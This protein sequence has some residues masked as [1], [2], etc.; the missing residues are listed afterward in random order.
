M[1]NKISYEEQAVICRAH[2]AIVKLFNKTNESVGSG[3]LIKLG[4]KYFIA[5]AAHVIP[6]KHSIEI[7]PVPGKSPIHRFQ[8]RGACEKNDVG[9]L[10]LLPGDENNLRD[11]AFTECACMASTIDLT[12]EY[13]VLVV[14]Y[15]VDYH[16]ETQS[17]ETICDASTFRT[18][19]IPQ[20][21]WPKLT[22]IDP[23][24]PIN[25]NT[26][27]FLDY[28]PLNG[29]IGFPTNESSLDLVHHP[30][31]TPPKPEGMSGGGI[32][33]YSGKTLKNSGIWSPGS[34]LLGIET[35]FFS[36]KKLMRGVRISAWCDL[37]RSHYPKEETV[38]EA[39][40]NIAKNEY[41]PKDAKKVIG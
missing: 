37:I 13:D 26:D 7:V 33:S 6:E 24:R 9:F 15:P 18:I 17:Q 5:T 32:W 41:P 20:K 14:G 38:I 10:E 21:K 28:D 25:K 12:S 3:V 36:K 11:E 27:I 40:N 31:S 30:D 1:D 34:Y 23:E 35:S 16:F 29:V 39:L 4:Q 22:E 2:S 8:L 19:I